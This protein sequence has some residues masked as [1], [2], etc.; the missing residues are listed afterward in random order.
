[1]AGEVMRPLMDHYKCLVASILLVA[2]ISGCGSERYEY[3]P[4]AAAQFTA[5]QPDDDRERVLVARLT[6]CRV[7]AARV[8]AR[9][10]I[11]APE[12]AQKAQDACK[13]DRE[14]WVASHGSGD[15]ATVA[16]DS[17]RC[18]YPMLVGYITH[19]RSGATAA[20]IQEWANSYPTKCS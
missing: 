14:A 6:L 12:A 1:M 4:V 11:P 3:Q 16:D 17:E 2:C 7:S 13:A 5:N 18:V 8:M 20:Q 19:I 9:I 10:N 15:A